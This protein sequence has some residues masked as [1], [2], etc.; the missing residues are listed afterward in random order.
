M[1]VMI[2]TTI[3][4]L[5][6][7]SQNL[8]PTSVVWVM[9]NHC[10]YII[11]YSMDTVF[12]EGKREKTGMMTS[13]GQREGFNTGVARESKERGRKW[14]DLMTLC[15]GCV[16]DIRTRVSMAWQKSRIVNVIQDLVLDIPK[17]KFDE[18]TVTCVHYV[19]IWGL[20]PLLYD[21][22]LVLYIQTRYCFI[23]I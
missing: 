13:S 14:I 6:Q 21:M 12:K 4:R 20:V 16:R 7:L 18:L 3:S 15:S 23:H 10:I 5:T 2:I 17:N 11:T 1:F 19:D 22:I 9:Y 8:L